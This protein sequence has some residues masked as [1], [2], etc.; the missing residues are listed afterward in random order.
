MSISMFFFFFYR[1]CDLA[2]AVIIIHRK[3][4]A[5]IGDYPSIG[6]YLAKFGYK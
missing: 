3:I 5:E 4:L 2:K 6:K 1:F